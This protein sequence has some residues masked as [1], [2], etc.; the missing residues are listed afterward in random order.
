MVKLSGD[1]AA[2]SDPSSTLLSLRHGLQKSAELPTP[3][4][5]SSAMMRLSIPPYKSNYPLPSKVE[6]SLLGRDCDVAIERLKALS[7]SVSP[8]AMIPATPSRI[9][10][11]FSPAHVRKMPKVCSMLSK[12]K[13]SVVQVDYVRAPIEQ[14]GATLYSYLPVEYIDYGPHRLRKGFHIGRFT[15]YCPLSHTFDSYV[16]QDH[17]QYPWG[18]SHRRGAMSVLCRKI[19]IKYG[20]NVR[21][22]C[23]PL[24]V[25]ISL[26]DNDIIKV[27]QLFGKHRAFIYGLLSSRTMRDGY[28]TIAK[29]FRVLDLNDKLCLRI[30]DKIEQDAFVLLDRYFGDIRKKSIYIAHIPWHFFISK[31]LDW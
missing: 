21:N 7:V 29:M 14:K 24:H 30:I 8:T 10:P 9:R 22:T 5:F 25:L 12:S 13:L 28:P 23:L 18:H 27:D 16:C 2:N 6:L 31:R 11:N 15:A 20:R 26:I 4:R 3:D 17:G 19:G 1:E